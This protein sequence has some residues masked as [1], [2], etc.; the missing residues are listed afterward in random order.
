MTEFGISGRS[1][2][3]AGEARDGRSDMPIDVAMEMPTAATSI[4]AETMG[5]AK[6]EPTVVLAT[7]RGYP[8]SVRVGTE[9][10]TPVWV[11]NR[12]ATRPADSW[13]AKPGPKPV[14]LRVL[15]GLARPVG[16]NLRF[17][18]SG[19]TLIVAFRY[20]TDNRKILRLGN[21]GSFLIHWPP[22]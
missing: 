1:D 6:F 17:C 21:C 5:T 8:A 18:I 10:K 16:S 14:N 3:D 4:A 19:F 22:Y 20:A 15:P 13:R 11:R 9:P 2:L 7:V 12:Q